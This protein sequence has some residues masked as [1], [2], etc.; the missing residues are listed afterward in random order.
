MVDV[1][2]RHLALVA[3]DGATDDVAATVSPGFR[4]HLDAM[5]TDRWG[6]L[7][8]IAARW[9]AEGDRPPLDVVRHTVSGEMVTVAIAPRAV[10]HFRTR[11][12][13]IDELWLTCDWRQWVAWLERGDLC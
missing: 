6:Y 8:L 3:V 5:E 2:C 4:L 9:A 1:V 7:A 13:L 12:D 11:G 10:A